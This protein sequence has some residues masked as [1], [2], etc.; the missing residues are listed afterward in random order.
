MWLL[1]SGRQISE[2][3]RELLLRPSTVSTYRQ[4]VFRKLKLSN[5][6]ELVQYAVRNQLV[7]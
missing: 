2:I 4:R 3:A 1:A 7:E 5:N 6:A